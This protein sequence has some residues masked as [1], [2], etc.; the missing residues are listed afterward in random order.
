MFGVVLGAEDGVE[1]GCPL[2]DVFGAVM[3]EEDGLEEG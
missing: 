3:G 1:D 2:G